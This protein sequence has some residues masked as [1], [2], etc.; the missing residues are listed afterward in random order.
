MS[1]NAEQRSTM[2]GVVS[3]SDFDIENPFKN[4][5]LI[6]HKSRENLQSNHFNVTVT[7]PEDSKKVL[8]GHVVLRSTLSDTSVKIPIKFNPE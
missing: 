5:E 1:L 4:S 2:I 3:I 7:V 6:I 8:N